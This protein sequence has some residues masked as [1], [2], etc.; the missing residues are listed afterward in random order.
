[1]YL[2]GIKW[3]IIGLGGDLFTL[4]QEQER[5]LEVLIRTERLHGWPTIN[6][7]TTVKQVWG[8]TS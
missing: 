3:L 8:W 5:L 4:R 7:Q 2:H 1:M 6:T